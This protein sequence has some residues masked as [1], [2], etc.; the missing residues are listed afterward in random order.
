M[1]CKNATLES[2]K[3]MNGGTR[4][5]GDFK[6]LGDAFLSKNPNTKL[7]EYFEY[8]GYNI[9]NPAGKYHRFIGNLMKTGNPTVINENIGGGHTLTITKIRQWT[10]KSNVKVWFGDPVITHRIIVQ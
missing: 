7:D 1:N 3:N 5:Q 10:P 6:R 2:I 8:F 4:T 9:E